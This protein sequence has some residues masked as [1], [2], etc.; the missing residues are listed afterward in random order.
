VQEALR[1]RPVLVAVATGVV[2]VTLAVIGWAVLRDPD[3]APAAGRH[4]A[5]TDPPS[6]AG[7]DSAS[8]EPSD[9]PSDPPSAPPGT[10]APSP[11]AAK[12]TPAPKPPPAAANP[13]GQARK[14]F[15]TF[16]GARDNDPPGSRNIAYPVIHKQADGKGTRA[17]PIT[18][19]TSKEELPIGTVVYYPPLRKYFVMEDLCVSCEEE[20]KKD[21]RP[22]IDLWAGES[23]DEGILRCE[24][25]LTPSGQVTVIVNPPPDLPV[26]PTRIY[27][28]SKCV[29]ARS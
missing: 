14:F 10:P 9:P 1:S 29:S 8:P 17:D 3:P 6:D 16:Y 23:T 27:D 18:F 15:V 26:D 24:E 7:S 4:G 22:H 13:P 20:W 11:S 12:P 19:A 28:G 21:R 2:V 5:P 25:S